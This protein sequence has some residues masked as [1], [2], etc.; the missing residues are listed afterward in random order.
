M[1]INKE[2]KDITVFSFRTF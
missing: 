2:K 1:T